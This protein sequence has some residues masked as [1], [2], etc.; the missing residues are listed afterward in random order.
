MNSFPQ[1]LIV[2]L[3]TIFVEVSCCTFPTILEKKSMEECWNEQKSLNVSDPAKHCKAL[4]CFFKKNN[5]LKSDLSL[6]K[7]ATE[8]YLN[9]QLKDNVEWLKLVKQIAVDQCLVNIE[10][11]YTKMMDF[12]KTNNMELPEPGTCSMKPMLMSICV[13]AKGFAHCP[14]NHWNKGSTC[15]EWKKYLENCTN[16]IENTLEFYKQLD[17]AQ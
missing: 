10:K 3:S 13:M 9:N 4:E 7:D 8:T 16:N 1:L 14:E 17:K 15:D 11:D 5:A 2:L 12:F 6:D